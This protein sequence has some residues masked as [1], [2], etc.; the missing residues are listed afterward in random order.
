[1]KK[2]LLSAL[3]ILLTV[4][5]AT[6]TRA[7]VG[8]GYYRVQNYV[9][10]RYA[11][12]MDDHAYVDYKATKVDLTAI[13]LWPGDEKMQSDPATVIYFQKV[14]DLYDLQAQG[15]GVYAMIQEYLHLRENSD[16]SYY[17]YGVYEGITK[18]LGDDNFNDEMSYMSDYTTGDYR[19]WYLQPIDNDTNNF[20]GL[21]PTVTANGDNYCVSYCGF[22]YKLAEGMQAYYVTKVDKRRACA[23]YAPIDTYVLAGTAAFV[24]CPSTSPADNK[25][26]IV[27]VDGG[28][29]PADNVLQGAYFCNTRYKH[30]SYVTYDA[31]TMRVLGTLSN[32]EL[33]YVTDESL[34]YV[35]RNTSYLVVP[36]GTPAEVKLVTQAEYDEI[37]ISDPDPVQKAQEIIWDDPYGDIFEGTEITLNAVATSGLEVS[38]E[39]LDGSANCQL[40]GNELKLLEPGKVMVKASQAGNDEYLPAE[41]VT[42][43]INVISGIADAIREGVKVEGKAIVNPAGVHIEVY[44]MQG[45]RIYAGSAARIPLQR[46]LYLLRTPSATLRISL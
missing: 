21:K 22:D 7:F 6:A 27:E 10:S 15:T 5:A 40:T 37:V 20:F 38:Y 2:F 3:A 30:E 41:P 18:Y 8:N 31:A 36:E 19:K 13:E 28:A 23:V 14:G 1:M 35:P 12:L 34:E 42:I 39:I 45:I 44:N 17:A 16:G 46:G 33:G 24:K 9:T 26:D 32:G 43:T 25:V 29:K 11:Y 4:S